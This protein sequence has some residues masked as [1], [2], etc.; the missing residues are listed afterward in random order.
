[1]SENNNTIKSITVHACPHCEKE[2]YVEN[3]FTPPTV[4]SIFTTEMVEAAKKDCLAR[5][6]TLTLE[7]GKREAVVK[8][9]NDP[10]TIFGPGEVDSIILSLLKED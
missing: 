5:I 10:E 1:M 6:E 4:E 8:W 7:D 3:R 9:L 2:F